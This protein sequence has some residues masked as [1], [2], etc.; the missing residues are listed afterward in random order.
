MPY[1]GHVLTTR[2]RPGRPERRLLPLFLVP[3][4]TP[5]F[6]DNRKPAAPHQGELDY[7][8]ARAVRSMGDPQ[9]VREAVRLL[10]K[11][12]RPLLHV[13]HGVLYAEAAP[14]LLEFAEL[15]QAPV[16]TTM[17]GKSAFPESHPLAAGAAG[18]TGSGV[19]AHFLKEADLVF[20]LGCSFTRCSFS[21]TIPP[22]RQK[23]QCSKAC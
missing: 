17:A 20:G 11:A 7:E 21:A 9:A 19:A 2:E 5:T 10:L 6:R 3:Y 12:K 4:R 16:M 18:N 1:I 13:G 23:R 8:P 22:G 14:E 15:L